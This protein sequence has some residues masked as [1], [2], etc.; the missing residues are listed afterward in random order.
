MDIS[1]LVIEDETYTGKALCETILRLRPEWKIL[2]LIGSVAE[3]VEYLNSNPAPNL[4][5]L[6][7]ELADGN[8]FSIFEQL[9][10]PSQSAIV[11]TTAYSE[12]AVKAFKY[13]S[14]DYLLKPIKE[15]ELLET[16]E[17]YEKL[18]SNIQQVVSEQSRKN[19]INYEQLSQIINS[20]QNIYRKRFLISKRESFFI[21]EVEKI[22]CFMFENRITYAVTF[23]NVR[24][25]LSNSM[26]GLEKE[27]DPA[28]F[29]R[30]NRQTIVNID[31]ID[32]FETYFNG[33]LLLKLHNGIGDKILISRIKA[34]QFKAWLNK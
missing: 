9:N 18:V 10:N 4:I 11:F 25:V 32:R 15:N 24:H 31:A 30:A 1:V 21:L 14:I 8:C 6:D 5:F 19:A 13:N 29:F 20:Q 12:Y 17:R 23:E 7:I 2:G 3:T 16:I 27:L 22:A 34:S 26:D 33:Q 28:K